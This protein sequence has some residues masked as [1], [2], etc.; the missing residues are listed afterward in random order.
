ME[1]YGNYSYSMTACPCLFRISENA[2]RTEKSIA[3][4]NFASYSSTTALLHYCL[5][6]LSFWLVK[7]TL[8]VS[9]IYLVI[10]RKLY[11]VVNVCNMLPSKMHG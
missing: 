3:H 4:A 10:L 7:C 8:K 6:D 2:R 9:H 5:R 1:M 11:E